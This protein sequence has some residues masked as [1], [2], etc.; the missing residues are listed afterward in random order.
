MAVDPACAGGTL[1]RRYLAAGVVSNFGIPP[2]DGE[3][4]WIGQL[5]GGARPIVIVEEACPGADEGN[6]EVF[7]KVHVGPRNRVAFSGT[8]GVEDRPPLNKP[9]ASTGIEI[10]RIAGK[11]QLLF[12]VLIHPSRCIPPHETPPEPPWILPFSRKI[13]SKHDVRIA[14]VRI[15]RYT[16]HDVIGV[17][18]SPLI[19]VTPPNARPRRCCRSGQG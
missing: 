6:D 4:K 9:V 15:Q 11:S 12:I 16:D 18:Q 14:I 3:G 10:R 19:C 1:N 8:V 5:V 13:I 17:W 7:G 2:V